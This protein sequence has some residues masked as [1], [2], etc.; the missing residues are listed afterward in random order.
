MADRVGINGFGRMERS[1]NLSSLV[2]HPRINTREFIAATIFR[3]AAGQK[4]RREGQREISVRFRAA[5]DAPAEELTVTVTWSIAELDAEDGTNRFREDLRKLRDSK[6]D[7]IITELAA[8]GVAFC[9]VP[10]LLPDVQITRVVRTGGRGDYYLN[11]RRDKMIEVSGTIEGSLTRRFTE[12]E[13]QILQNKRLT[14]A[15]VSVTRFAEPASIL[16]R[17]L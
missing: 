5:T 12:K 17:V 2:A 1:I 3:L 13:K 4:K 11:G 15:Y 6:D 10:V 8:L 9:L 14:K 7:R 16:M